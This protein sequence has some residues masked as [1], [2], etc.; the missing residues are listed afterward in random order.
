MGLRGKLLQIIVLPAGAVIIFAI[1]AAAATMAKPG[2]PSKCGDVEIPFPFGLSEACFLDESF[3]ITC[4]SEK[5]FTGNIPVRNISIENHE[6]H[7]RTLVARDCYQPDGRRDPRNSTTLRSPEKTIS[8]TKNKFTVIG[9]DTYAY[10]SVVQNGENYS[11]GCSSQCPSLHNVVNGSCSGVGCCE[12]GFPDGLKNITVQ[13]NSFNNHTKVWNFNPCGYAFFVEKGEF[14]FSTDYLRNL[15]KEWVPLVLDWTVGN[16]P[17]DNA[18]KTTKFACKENSECLDLQ[19]SRG[20]HCKCKQGYQ[21]NPYLD[22]GC[23]GIIIINYFFFL[24]NFDYD[25]R[26]GLILFSFMIIICRH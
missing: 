3:N 21:G 18:R 19:T 11:F 4:Q 5:P 12:V 6:L 17:C 22:G 26:M 13:V 2:C 20:Y 23:Q 10:L 7:V 25:Y 24:Q 14:N 15:T 16:Q 8:N 1:V 9:C